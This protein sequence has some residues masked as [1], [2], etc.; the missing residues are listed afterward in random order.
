MS[1]ERS[2]LFSTS[3]SMKMA[4]GVPSIGSKKSSLLAAG[5]SSWT[6]RT[7]GVGE[8]GLMCAPRRVEDLAGAMGLARLQLSRRSGWSP[9]PCPFFQSELEAFC[10]KH[11]LLPHP[12]QLYF[13]LSMV[14]RSFSGGDDHLYLCIIY[15]SAS[16]SRS[17]MRGILPIY[18]NTGGSCIQPL[19]HSSLPKDA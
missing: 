15:E 8:T 19:I 10:I 5:S 9:T 11:C 13:L 14:L 6:S 4:R 2:S 1:C 18:S 17:L 12:P 7:G 3:F 16:E